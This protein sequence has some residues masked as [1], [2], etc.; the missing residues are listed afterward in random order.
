MDEDDDLWAEFDEE[1]IED[2]PD[3]QPTSDDIYLKYYARLLYNLK[4]LMESCESDEC[5]KKSLTDDLNDENDTTATKSEH[6]NANNDQPL[7]CMK[8]IVLYS[9]LSQFRPDYWTLVNGQNPANI[10]RIYAKIRRI[11]STVKDS[12]NCLFQVCSR[13]KTS[14]KYQ[15]TLNI[16]ILEY[17]ELYRLDGEE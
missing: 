6:L 13:L 14:S 9:Q 5:V 8:I 16:H 10:R 15:P 1:L 7:Y 11:L 2:A 12:I 4:K 3:K 17:R